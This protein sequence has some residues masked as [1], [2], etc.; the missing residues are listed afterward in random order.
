M[1]KK[2]LFCIV[3]L[4][5]LHGFAQS[6]VAGKS[7]E[8]EMEQERLSCFIEFIDSDDYY[9][10]VSSQETEDIVYVVVLSYGK[11]KIEDGRV[12]LMDALHDYQM[13]MV[14]ADETLLM[15]KGFGF[16]KGKCFMFP[17]TSYRTDI[18]GGIDEDINKA[19]IQEERDRYSVQN[20]EL[21]NLTYG[22]YKA[23]KFA[24][25]LDVYENN[26]YCFGFRDCPFSKGTFKRNGN[27]LNLYDPSLDC[28][29]YLLIGDDNR[30]ISKSLPGSN[31]N[32][33][34]MISIPSSHQPQ[35]G[36]FGCSRIR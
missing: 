13:E 16:M 7:Y 2:L 27:V 28:T 5:S 20:K 11:Y 24:F 8:M 22:K 9:I 36:G 34:K 18:P 15:Q 35:K 26:T 10:E 23:I 32:V 6:S 12:V 19:N 14:L 29:F 4:V 3:A 1:L 33:F 30:L 17:V 21:H 31:G 25:D